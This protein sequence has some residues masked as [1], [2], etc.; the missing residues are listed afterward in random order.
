MPP[1]EDPKKKQ[2]VWGKYRNWIIIGAALVVL[3]LIGVGVKVNSTPGNSITL[4]SLST[5]LQTVQTTLNNQAMILGNLPT[6]DSVADVSEIEDSIVGIVSELDLINAELDAIEV[7]LAILAGNIS[8]MDMASLNTTMWE[9]HKMLV[10]LCE[11]LNVT[12]PGI[13][14][15]G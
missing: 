2:G 4:T 15:A 3:I 13:V 6:T 1:E 8:S 10:A 11:S 12:V 9:N 14:P 7:E 5:Q